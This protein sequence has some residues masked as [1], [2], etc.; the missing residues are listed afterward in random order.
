[1][2]G[3]EHKGTGAQADPAAGGQGA[4]GQ[5]TGDHQEE[6]VPV[7][8]VQGIRTELNDQKRLNESLQDQINLYK[9]NAVTGQQ[10]PGPAGPAAPQQGDAFEGMGEDEVLTVADAKKIFGGLGTQLGNTIRDMQMGIT[11]SDYATVVTKHLPNVLK[12]NPALAQAIR[13]SANPQLLAYTLAKTDPDYLK[14][15][16][17]DTIPSGLE[18]VLNR[19]NVPAD[20][21]ATILKE[22][23]GSGESADPNVQKIIE[24]AEKPGSAGAAA[25]ASAGLTGAD[26]Y[27]NM[28][29]EELEKRIDDVK[30]R[31]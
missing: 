11:N 26:Y 20:M 7:S 21:K 12:T 17:G 5:P 1:M 27:A 14:E 29:D 9:V 10:Q 15:Q 22:F 31:G 13:T 4:Q 23:S 25:G 8:V 30:S 28:S 6:M 16:T 24:N 18:A 3:E 19:A 2:G